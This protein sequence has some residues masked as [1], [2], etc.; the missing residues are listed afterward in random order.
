MAEI[1]ICGITTKD[2]ALFV[3]SLGVDALGFIFYPPSPR[4]IRPEKALEIISALPKDVAKVG[5]FV[6][7]DIGNV[8]QIFEFCR[9]DLIQLHG[10]ETPEYCSMYNPAHLIK[11][12][13]I[14]SDA[15][16]NALVNYQVSALLLDSRDAERYGGTGKT[17]DWGLAAKLN[18]LF[19][20]VLSGGLSEAN[21]KGAL[22]EVSPQAVDINSGVE[23]SPG[24]KD[25]DKMRRVVELI[26]TGKSPAT[27]RRIFEILNDKER[28]T[29][30]TDHEKHTTR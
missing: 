18:A 15:E 17:C 10:D 2:D 4:Y 29:K 28:R 6:N 11:A 9:L 12:V 24:K 19:P 5:V 22:E 7:Q 30:R 13:N 20:L 23:L 1:K 3:A 27:E 16:L 8:K 26:H 25:W 14:R 21:I